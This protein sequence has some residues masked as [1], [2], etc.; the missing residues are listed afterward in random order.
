MKVNV[1]TVSPV[2]KKLLIEVD[3]DRVSNEL[4]RAYR[5]L[6]RSVR[7]PGFRQGKVPRRILEARYK[8]QVEQDVVQHLVEHTWREAVDE[9]DLFPVAQ[10]VVS[11]ER[12]EQG[13][14]FKYEARVEVKPEVTAKDYKG[15]EYT[16]TEPKVTD[17]MVNDELARIQ[18]SLAQLQP[19]EDRQ[20]AQV[21]DYAIIDHEGFLGEESIE[22]GKGTD[23][24]VKVD[25]GSLLEGSAPM[26]AGKNV[27]ETVD[28]TVEFPPDYQ[29]EKVRGKAATFKLTLKSLKRRDVPALDDEL[30]KDLGGEAKTLDELKAKIREGLDTAEKQRADR[31]NREGLLKALVEKNPIEVPKALVERGIDMMV[32]GAAERFQRQ[33]LDIRQMGLDFRKI[34]EDLREKATQEVKAA[35][36][37]EAIAGQEGVEVSDSDLADH[38][39]KL[40]T[41]VNMPEA[42]VRAHF[43]KDA[44]E[45]NALKNRLREEKTVAL[46]QREAKVTG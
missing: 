3:A 19:I 32:A 7:V 44:A 27:G 5:G 16:G 22:G 13:K 4:E 28:A 25:E 2:E 9:Q 45:M 35:L 8:D 30:A 17:E 43:E 34:R 15:L 24:T 23:V 37:L 21:G 39:A 12:L 36:L 29:D 40:A 14:P 18:E 20:T 6:S 10:P 41:E 31:E 26:L 11:P 38:Y 42:K 33:G 46:L 1:E